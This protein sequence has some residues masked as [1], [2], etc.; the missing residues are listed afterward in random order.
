MKTIYSLILPLAFAL[1]SCSTEG[2]YLPAER[3]PSPEIENTAVIMDQ[4]LK[5]MIAVDNQNAERTSQG[6]LKALANVRNRTNNDITVQFQTVFRDAGGFSIDDDT[7]WE[8][9]VLTSNE[10][11]TISATSTNRKAERYTIRI[12]MMR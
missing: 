1:S 8:T 3:Q 6:K 9:T 10:T 11:R 7:A 5:D 2:P 4:E 12:R